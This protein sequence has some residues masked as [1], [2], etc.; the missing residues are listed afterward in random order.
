M[1]KE[2]FTCT[3][4][5]ARFQRVGHHKGPKTPSHD[6][7]TSISVK[8]AANVSV[9]T[10]S[11]DEQRRTSRSEVGHQVAPWRRRE[12]SSPPTERIPMI[13]EAPWRKRSRSEDRRPGQLSVKKNEPA[14]KQ[15]LQLLKKPQQLKA[16]ETSVKTSPAWKGGA[17]RLRKSSP[18]RRTSLV[19]TVPPLA[20]RASADIPWKSGVQLLKKTSRESSPTKADLPDVPQEANVPWKIGVQMLKKTSRDSSPAAPCQSEGQPQLGVPWKSVQL[21]KTSG[22]RDVS[23]EKRDASSQL[24][25]V[26]EWKAGKQMLRKGSPA[27]VEISQVPAVHKG[28]DKKQSAKA[29]LTQKLATVAKEQDAISGGTL[30]KSRD[31]TKP[32]SIEKVVQD[33]PIP[34]VELKPTPQKPKADEKEPIQVVLK[35][36]PSQIQTTLGDSLVVLKPIDQDEKLVEKKTEIKSTLKKAEQT[37]TFGRVELKKTPQKPKEIA[38]PDQRVEL[39][40][41]AQKAKIEQSKQ[42]EYQTE[43][44]GHEPTDLPDSSKAVLQASSVELPAEM[45]STEVPVLKQKTKPT[46]TTPKP[47]EFVPKTAITKPAIPQKPTPESIKPTEETTQRSSVSMERKKEATPV[48]QTEQT[49]EIEFENK[50]ETLK[51]ITEQ[52]SLKQL[53]KSKEAIVTVPEI[54]LKRT[55]QSP[56]E[57]KIE[58]SK[59]E[60]K[61]VTRKDLKP[62]PKKEEPKQLKPVVAKSTST[63]GELVVSPSEQLKHEPESIISQTTIAEVKEPMEPTPV[64]QEPENI[65]TPWR[66]KKTLEPILAKVEDSKESTAYP[67]ESITIDA[68]LPSPAAEPSAIPGKKQRETID[69]ADK[70]PEVVLKRTPQKIKQEETVQE[71]IQLKR[72]PHKSKDTEESSITLKPVYRRDEEVKI[73]EVVPKR[74]LQKSQPEVVEFVGIQLKKV[75]ERKPKEIPERTEI[76]LKPV[77]GRQNEEEQQLPSD[78]MEVRSIQRDVIPQQTVES[79]LTL[80]KSSPDQVSQSQPP[81]EKDEG[82]PAMPTSV[83][84]PESAPEAL[85]AKREVPWRKKIVPAVPHLPEVKEKMVSVPVSKPDETTKIS[86][87]TCVAETEPEQTKDVLIETKITLKQAVT[88]VPKQESQIVPKVLPEE[89]PKTQVKIDSKFETVPS[90]SKEIPQTPQPSKSVRRSPR[91]PELVQGPQQV[92]LKRTPQK[93]KVEEP[94]PEAIKLKKIPQREV[95]SATPETQPNIPTSMSRVPQKTT[96]VTSDATMI[97]KPVTPPLKEIEPKVVT[98]I[99]LIPTPEIATPEEVESGA[100]ERTIA[101]PDESPKL[102]VVSKSLKRSPQQPEQVQIPQ[103]VVLKRTPQ[104][105]K[106]DAPEPEMIQLKKIPRQEVWPTLIPTHRMETTEI[107]IPD[108]K[109]LE[110]DLPVTVE[111]KIDV[112]PSWRKP[113][114]PSVAA[115]QP[116]EEKPAREPVSVTAVPEIVPADDQTPSSATARLKRT[117]RKYIPDI[118]ESVSMQIEQEELKPMTPTLTSTATSVQLKRPDVP[119][120]TS[121]SKT[122]EET[123]KQE[124]MAEQAVSMT[125]SKVSKTV[126]KTELVQSASVEEKLRLPKMKASIS[127]TPKCQP[128]SFTKKLQPLS[129]RTGKKVRL[130]CQFQGEPQPTITWYR[131]ESVLLPGADRLDITTEPTSSVLEISQVVLEDTGIYTCRAV[132]EAGSAITSANFIVQG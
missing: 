96:D 131:N 8:T 32:I 59:V 21:R 79:T 67:S 88:P 103:Q 97:F 117:Q 87:P 9:A 28:V 35:K 10:T 77:V 119:A 85:E 20:S 11:T 125:T 128:P 64:D 16:E 13:E 100:T 27:S 84:L 56:G 47:K 127:S 31:K 45:S 80:A 75:P 48:N 58:S 50:E 94:Q 104:K 90:E 55:P 5:Q 118:V 38:K 89:A 52:V 69:E 33:E 98:E 129:S 40:P 19:D 105:P 63:E 2:I 30:H 34:Q 44:F 121:Q 123:V 70:I 29:F 24:L 1:L 57:S 93:P 49:F 66:T 14:W 18:N 12:S 3:G 115:E 39:K 109:E 23:P 73:A 46:I 78:E 124:I 7:T 54:Q 17:E 99:L 4:K 6:Q 107:E 91:E 26:I 82:Q 42:F 43:E 22:S 110:P 15:G 111:A 95:P 86:I 114:L 120:I 106:Q 51:A 72:V 53:P 112:S 62:T 81:S 132:N 101:E 122:E 108:D 83:T 61:K 60:L 116:I 37:E 113:R 41:I 65:V 76:R 36:I 74:T 102:V 92:V 71:N 68:N 25:D 126:P 130:H